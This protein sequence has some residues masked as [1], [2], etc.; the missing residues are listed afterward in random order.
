MIPAGSFRMGC[1]VDDGECRPSEFPVTPVE[2]SAF[3]L[4]KYEVT[5]ADWDA[6]VVGG[7]CDGYRPRADFGGGSRP[8]AHVDYGEAQSYIAWLSE[9][10]GDAYRLPSEAEW[11]YAA[12]A[13]TRTKYHWG[14][15]VGVDRARCAGC[16]SPDDV[17]SGTVPV[18]SFEA[19]AW[20]LH[21][22]H[23]NVEEFVADCWNDS[24]GGQPQDGRARPVESCSH[25]FIRVVR[26]GS[27]NSS[28]EHIRAAVRRST[29]AGRNQFRGFRVARELVP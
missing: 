9:K 28:A 22:M 6:C 15:E 1:L 5:Y 4:S 23:G 19:N 29:S 10:T 8:V 25:E 24:Y 11:E 17:A 12:R 7:G 16:N 27:S 20:G 3:A 18:G 2:V 14:N 21:D 13:G 26:G